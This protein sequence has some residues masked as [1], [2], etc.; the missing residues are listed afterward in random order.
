[1][2]AVRNAFRGFTENLEGR[3]RNP[4]ADVKGLPTVAFG[5]LITPIELALMLD[6]RIGDRR[7]TEAEV[8][9]DWATI[10]AIGENN[11]TAA[12]QASLTSI[13]LSDD[14][15]EALLWRR[16]DANVSWLVRHSMP[17]LASFP[18]DAQLGIMSTVWAIGCDFQRTNPPRPEL[19]DACNR[20]DWLVA[21]DHSRLTEKG[22]AGVA[23]RNA[24]SALCFEN[25]AVVAA[26]QLPKVKLWW[27]NLCPRVEAVPPPADPVSTF[28]GQSFSR[29]LEAPNLG[30]ARALLEYEHDTEPAPPPSQPNDAT[31]GADS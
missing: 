12:N 10:N 5:C 30:G 22:N 31:R 2:K 19:I 8:R 13:R 21:K 14:A 26:Q 3:T 17:G 25:A 15:V 6:W 29:M 16:F 28:V 27:P 9:N 18:A 11:R 20:G 24:A 23:A 1:M 4:Y 7:A